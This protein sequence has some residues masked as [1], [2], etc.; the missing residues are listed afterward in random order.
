MKIFCATVKNRMH[1]DPALHNWE[2][3]DEDFVPT[4]DDV[5]QYLAM[6]NVLPR[7]LYFMMGSAPD[8]SMGKTHACVYTAEVD[9]SPQVWIAINHEYLK[10]FS[11]PDYDDL[12]PALKLRAKFG[13]ASTLMHEMGH[14]VWRYRSLLEHKRA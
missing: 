2:Y 11:R 1:E 9:G 4:D 13:L 10:F 12:G 7:L 8:S 14:V 5:A 3:L 6:M